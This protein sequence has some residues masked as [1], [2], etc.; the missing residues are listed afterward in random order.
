MNIQAFRKLLPMQ[1]W[2][3]TF[4]REAFE[5]S[6]HPTQE[7]IAF[8]FNG[9]DGKSYDGEAR[10]ARVWHTTLAGY[11]DAE[12]VKVGKALHYIDRDLPVREKSTGIQHPTAW[13]VADIQRR[14]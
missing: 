8:T 7:R 12:F 9:W 10:T 14:S 6:F 3:T 11:E 1:D 4:T 13:W 2:N 5:S